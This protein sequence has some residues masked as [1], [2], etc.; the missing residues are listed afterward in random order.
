MELRKAIELFLGE[1]KASTRHSYHYPMQSMSDWLGPARPITDIKPEMLI[2]Y[3]QW[4]RQKDYAPATVRK[5]L[6]TI[7]TFWNWCVRVFDE[8]ERS[9][10]RSLRS[11]KVPTAV[12][13][14][15]AMQNDELAAVLDAVR[16]KPRDYALILFLADTGCRRGGAV[17]LRLE[18]INWENNR[19][20][21]TEKGERERLVEFGD[22]C[23]AALIK[24]L[25]VRSKSYA[26]SGEKLRDGTVCVYVFSR[27]GE[28]MKAE[29]VSLIIRRA[30]KAAGIRVLSSHSLRHRKGHE[31]ADARVNPTIAAT[32]L[33]HASVHTYLEHYAPHDQE[34]ALRTLREFAFDPEESPIVPPNVIDF[35]TGS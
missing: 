6:K 30:C 1:Y 25:A 8:I 4:V 26:I 21:V 29:N 12:D 3:F 11:V 23:A 7:K 16:Y 24:W 19:A 32:A 17:G 15:K 34:T 5:H 27:H 14:S 22:K 20:K 28:A 9:P 10:A 31:L 2:E 33:G 18:D 13:R 35:G